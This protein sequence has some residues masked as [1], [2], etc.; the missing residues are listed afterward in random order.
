MSYS[1]H[2]LIGRT[3]GK[4]QILAV[5]GGGGMGTVYRARQLG[6]QREVAVKVLNVELADS[7]QFVRRF[8]REAEA[9]AKLEHPH[10]V[11]VLDFGEEGEY[12]YLVM[13]LKT[14]GNLSQVIREGNVPLTDV[15]RYIEQIASALDYAHL[16]GIIHRDL[17]P[18]NILLDEERNTFLTDFGIARRL[19][20]TRL[21]GQGTVVGSPTYM[22][23]E[24]WR[25]E[26]P[27][28]ETDV[29][30]LGV[31]FFQLLT[32]KAPFEETNAARLMNMHLFEPPLSLRSFR[33][34]LD[35]RFERVVEAAL[36]KDR[37]QRF[38]SAGEMAHAVRNA[39][40]SYLSSGQAPVE[41]SESE[42]TVILQRTELKPPP[43]RDERIPS[44][45]APSASPA[46]QPAFVP[47]PLHV[48]E[49][50]MPKTR[51]DN[52][53]IVLIGMSAVIIILLATIILLLL[54]R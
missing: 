34:E 51:S 49:A 12:L 33:P 44:R 29:Y 50:P 35:K 30:S 39:I 26:E 32:G 31:I 16:R 1:T 5:V 8:K 52:T 54:S 25:G 28:P 45:P 19:G 7:E 43:G 11:P 41:A 6:I 24:A 4:Y 40:E 15:Q 36:A 14:G 38:R 27:S 9:L 21:T 17:K 37:S 23:P 47:T 48:E 20:E 42:E 22:A 46:P 53:R 3:I 13:A 10:I 18:A 2:T